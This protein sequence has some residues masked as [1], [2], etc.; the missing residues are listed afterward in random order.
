MSHP[1]LDALRTLRPRNITE[2]KNLALRARAGADALRADVAT[3]RGEIAELHRSVKGLQE[4]AAAERRSHTKAL[5]LLAERLEA[6]QRQGLD[7]LL[8]ELAGVKREVATVGMR[9][10]QLRSIALRD[11]QLESHE[12]GL[13]RLLE[14][15]AIGDHIRAAIAR[16]TLEREPF[17][18]MIVDGLLPAPLFDALVTGLP[19]AELF[20]DRPINKQQLMVPMNL[21][22]AYTRRVWRFMARRIIPEH[23]MPALIEAF[24]QPLHAWLA[25]EL[26]EL[27]PAQIDALEFTCSDGRI[28]LRRPGYHIPPHRDPKWGFIT[29]LMYLPRPGDDPRWGTHLYSVTNETD[30]RG[31][32]PHWIDD[33]H[34]RLVKTVEFLPNRT[35]F[36]LNSHGAHGA[37]IPPDAPPA[38]ERYAYQ[39]RIGPGGQAIEN[40]LGNLSPERLVYWKGKTTTY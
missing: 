7:A 32:A 1:V 18:H 11:R 3:L 33:E 17:P 25:R 5:R 29:G 30:A 35:L 40:I 12:R 37:D 26:P 14:D 6:S 16:T 21:A 20:A 36:F 39:F 8:N 9:E 22:P 38:L 4:A 28:L 27:T 2:T 19:P 10:S 13:D 31:A 24:R 15:P 23:L 34:C